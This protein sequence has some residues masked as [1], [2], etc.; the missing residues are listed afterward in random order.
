M[1]WLKGLV[2]TER[3]AARSD[4]ADQW[5]REAYECECR[6]DQAGADRLYRQVLES[7]PGHTDA[8]YFLGRMAALDQR[9]DEAIELLQRAVDLRPAE[10]L[11]TLEL[12]VAL[13]DARRFEEAAAVLGRCIPLQPDCTRLRN[14]Y[15]VALIEL[16][17]RDEALMELERLQALKYRVNAFEI[18]FN[19]GGIYRE[20][21]RA[22]D[23][24]EAYRRALALKPDDAPTY[25]NLLLVLN[26]SSR[27]DAASIF[28]EHQRFG[29]RFAR[30]Y[31]APLPDPA[32]PRRLRVGY[33]SPDFRNHVVMR[34]VWP[35]LAGHDRARFE[36]SCYHTD[37]RKD[38]FTERLR[39]LAEHWVDAEEYS[40]EQLAER[41]R[42]DRIDLLVDLAGHTAGNRVTVLAM[43]PAPL[44]ATYLGYPNTTGLAAVDYRITD[45]FADPPGDAD[46]FSVDRLVRLP[47]SYF[48]YRPEPAAPEVAPLPARRAGAVTFGCFNNFAKIS[49][50]FL[51]AAARLLSRLPESR[52]V[53]KARPLGFA[54]V[55]ESVRKRFT[56]AGVDLARLELRGWEDGVNNHLSVY[57]GVDIALDSFPYNGATTTC[58]A[59]WMGVPVVSLAGD[60]HAG[61]AASSLLHAVGLGHLVAKDFDGYIAICVELATDIR[62]LAELRGGLRERMRRSRLM[63]EAG[64]VRSLE[65][66]YL[67]LWE[68]RARGLG[69]AG[70]AQGEGAAMQVAHAQRLRAAGRVQEARAIAE[71]IL[72]GSPAQLEALT[73]VWDLAFEGGTPGGA[74]ELINRALA[75]NEGVHAFHYMLGCSFEALGRMDDAIAAFRRARELD[76]G[77]AKTH[78]NMGYA[79][80]AAGRLR[81]AAQCYREA[82]ARD[83]RMAQALYNL[84]NAHAQL[85]EAGEAIR[86]VG[87]ALA[88]E[89]A[90]ADWRC[91]LGSLRFGAGALDAAIADFRAATEVDPR[92]VRAHGELGDALLVAGR[93]EEARAAYARI[94]EL[95]PGFADAESRLLM[96]MHFGAAEAPEPL[97]ARHLAWRDHHARELPRGTAHRRLDLRNPKLNVGYVAPRFTQHRLASHL[98][99]VLAAQDRSRF[100]LFC[101]STGGAEDM[102]ARRAWGECEWRDLSRFPNEH[103][104]DRIRADGIDI[105]VDLAGHSGGGRFE[106]FAR[107]PAPVQAA[108]LGY[109]DTTGLDTIDYRLTDA[110]ADPE[111]SER[112][113]T[114]RLVRLPRGFLC[115]RPDPG[116]PASSEARA[117]PVTFGCVTDLAALTPEMLALWARILGEVAGSRLV[118]AARGFAAA[119]TRREVSER[120][121][122]LGLAGNRVELRIPA[123]AA[124]AD[125]DIALD[126]FP[127]NGMTET[128]TALWV[129]VPVVT[130]AGSRFMSRIGASILEHAGLSQ[131]VAET[132]E[133]YLAQ[134]VGLAGRADERRRLRV[135]LREKLAKSPLL[136]AAGFTKALEDTY[137]TLWEEKRRQAGKSPG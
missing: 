51:D 119:S 85:G 30:R 133:Q 68:N 41:I 120:L 5:L 23:A 25:G 50:P 61:R 134:A 107:K 67:E 60:R 56:Q 57:H 137:R 81:E 59:L 118:L 89:P 82:V 110:V 16:N 87:E 114:E 47:G 33:L 104:A 36:I 95:E 108:W 112:F 126:T 111:G 90:H 24:V 31:E 75:V 12:G 78:N 1:K 46:R 54:S 28:A 88:I 11:Y 35:I 7:D 43:K 101:Y 44:Q 117:G 131:L 22:D 124:Y 37:R 53:L 123:H 136:D 3:A 80:E 92:Y 91:N 105:L 106:I 2:R 13:V 39:T 129:G 14:N 49:A 79:L 9:V 132:P 116:V 17:R 73:L 21:G 97:Y 26:Y 34:F 10:I 71:K 52:L 76:A 128:C 84:G 48:C 98:E 83:P 6:G 32:W 27:E 125:I 64:F 15:A 19:L 20:F 135:G 38:D 45:A 94:L 40:D 121:A 65:A 66:C 42:T 99:P 100:R 70:T 58:E 122:A 69:L 4:D 115:Y 8:L 109:P 62:A 86:L 74:V 63:D 102:Q 93:V 55:V 130:L 127:F 72:Q 103:A 18:L 29:A 77:H 113:Y 96:A